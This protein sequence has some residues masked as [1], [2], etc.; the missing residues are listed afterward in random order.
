L[1]ATVKNV[2]N[3]SSYCRWTKTCAGDKSSYCRR[4]RWC[5]GD[6][7]IPLARLGAPGG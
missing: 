5:V 6:K 3:T 4:T 1:L 2:K 7:A